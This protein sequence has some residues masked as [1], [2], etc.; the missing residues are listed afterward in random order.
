MEILCDVPESELFGAIFLGGIFIKKMNLLSKKNRR[1]DKCAWKILFFV[2][3]ST[4]LVVR[5]KSHVLVVSS[6]RR[7]RVSELCRTVQ[8]RTSFRF[9]DC[10]V[11]AEQH[12]YNIRRM[13]YGIGVR[14]ECHCGSGRFSRRIFQQSVCAVFVSSKKNRIFCDGKRNYA[15]VRSG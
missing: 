2:P 4:I 15:C 1:I 12:S 8:S 9:A 6:R 13:H 11:G 5:P 10:G 3:V 7:F 14:L